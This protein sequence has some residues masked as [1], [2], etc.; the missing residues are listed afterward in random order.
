M[1]K[2]DIEKYCILNNEILEFLNSVIEKFD[3]SARAYDKVIKVART[4]AD[5]EESENIEIRHLSEA[6][7]YRKK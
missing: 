1:K 7:N 5:L 6:L 4:I 2:K 3:L